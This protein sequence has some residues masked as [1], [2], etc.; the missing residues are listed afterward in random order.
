[1]TTAIPTH[2]AKFIAERMRQDLE[3][4]AEKAADYR[5]KA[6]TVRSH[7]NNQPTPEGAAVFYFEADKLDG[8]AD[9]QDAEFSEL[10]RICTYLT[11]AGV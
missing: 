4:A 1:M 8:K 10:E 5:T 3:H 6:H 11:R 7:G 2:T 9:R